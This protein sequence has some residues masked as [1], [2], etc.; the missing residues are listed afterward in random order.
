MNTPTELQTNSIGHF[1]KRKGLDH[2]FAPGKLEGCNTEVDS[3]AALLNT[4]KLTAV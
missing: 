3:L 2:L 1:M 4:G